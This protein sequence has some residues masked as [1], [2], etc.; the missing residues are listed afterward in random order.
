MDNRERLTN[1]RAGIIMPYNKMSTVY[2]YAQLNKLLACHPV[3][4]GAISHSINP[5]LFPDRYHHQA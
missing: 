1:F 4:Q 2:F 5:Y 3:M